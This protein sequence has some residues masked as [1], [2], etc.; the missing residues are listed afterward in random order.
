VRPKAISNTAS[1]VTRSTA[2]EVWEAMRETPSPF[3]FIDPTTHL[4]IDANDPYAALFEL[5][6]SEIKGVSVISLYD[7]EVGTTIESF[8][9][10]FARGTL[11]IVRGQGSLRRSNGATIEL[12]GWSRRIE[13]ISDRPLVVTSAVDTKSDATLPDDGFWVAQAPHVFGLP[14]DWS[15]NSHGNPARRADQLEKHL[16]R[17]TVEFRAAD[18]TP[19][20]GEA[21]PPG[22][23]Q[24]IR[25]DDH[26][27]TGDRREACRRR[28]GEGDRPRHVPE[29]KH[30]SQSPDGRC[31]VDSECILSWSSS[32]FSRTCR[33]RR[34]DTA[35]LRPHSS[36]FAHRRGG[37]DSCLATSGTSPSPIA[38]LLANDLLV[39]KPFAKSLRVIGALAG[40]LSGNAGSL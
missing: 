37:T 19:A 23:D 16:W 17:I 26:A 13:G 40:A 34:R 12:N 30:G 39:G 3:A 20:L 31:S 18:L 2:S 8:H 5:A 9:G 6:A 25:R 29:S 10:A 11:Q 38:R 35:V 33:L 28:E 24:G 27:P 14:D 7:P 4:F 22:S 21:L 36:S 1:D 15:E 32:P